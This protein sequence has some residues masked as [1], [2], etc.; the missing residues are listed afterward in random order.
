M[1]KKILV[2]EDEVSLRNVLVEKLKSEDF[3]V[4]EARNGEEGLEISI[5][6]KPN[7]ILLDII[8]PKMDGLTMLEKLREDSWGKKVPVVILT[9]LSSGME[10]SKSAEN[11]VSSYLVKTDWKLEDVVKKVKEIL[12]LA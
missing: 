8:M 2:V 11:G 3:D 12:K 4:I 9:N 1:N 6:Q 10:M 5:S 7:L